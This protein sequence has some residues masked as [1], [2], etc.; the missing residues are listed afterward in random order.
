ME[1]IA[2]AWPWLLHEDPIPASLIACAL[3]FGCSAPAVTNVDNEANAPDE[4]STDVPSAASD[5]GRNES[6]SQVSD[7]ISETS[8]DTP[9]AGAVDRIDSTQLGT[10]LWVFACDAADNR[11]KRRTR[12][13]VGHDAIGQ[14]LY[15][16]GSWHTISTGRTC[17]SAPTAM[18]FYSDPRDEL[19]VYWRD[20][21]GDV[22]EA[23]YFPG[24]GANTTDLSSTLG[25]GPILGIPTVADAGITLGSTC[26]RR[27]ARRN[28]VRENAAEI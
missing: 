10:E 9:A 7:A 19:R 4:T 3:L 27:A 11:M 15:Q 23:Q 26:A 2:A 13:V 5:G 18:R 24:G 28:D 20:L 12:S 14:E 1:Q 22:I 21:A 8:Y 6:V 17:A 25:F 16:W